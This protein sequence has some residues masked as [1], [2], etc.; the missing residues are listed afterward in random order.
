[1]FIHIFHLQH[2]KSSLPD[3]SVNIF[4]T[5]PHEHLTGTGIWTKHVRDGKELPEIV[6]DEF[7]DFNYQ[8]S[9]ILHYVRSLT[10]DLTT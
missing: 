1:M 10:L 9:M 7:Y 4:A 6:R 3:N 8:V 2:L 5:F